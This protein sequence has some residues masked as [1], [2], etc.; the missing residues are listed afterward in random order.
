MWL[1]TKKTTCKY[2]VTLCKAN[3]NATLSPNT[4]HHQISPCNINAS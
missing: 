4:D 3:D 2:S 1:S